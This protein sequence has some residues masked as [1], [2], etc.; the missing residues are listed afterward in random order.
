[1]MDRVD[2]CRKTEIRAARH[3][4]CLSSMSVHTANARKR[5]VRLAVISIAALS[6]SAVAP[7][8]ES[9]GV[10]FREDWAESPAEMPVSQKHVANPDLLL[11]VWGPGLH[12]IKKSNHPWIANDPF[13]IW[14][15]AC[16]GNWAV[17]L[18]HRNND[19]DLTNNA[20]IRWRTRQAGFRELRIILRLANGTWLVSDA[21]DGPSDEWRVREFELTKVR[22]RVL[23]ISR[24]TEGRWAASAN[25]SR[26]EAVGFTDLMPGGLSDACS[27]LDWI[28]VYG[29]AVDRAR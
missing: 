5:F 11:E 10:F 23:D 16:P 12:G 9:T 20:R 3:D 29:K 2:V 17:S 15:G 8:L 1:M 26:V 25:L 24:V 18:K 22:W 6:V 14:S 4:D 28:E 7:G 21:S 27:R 19:A 13:Y